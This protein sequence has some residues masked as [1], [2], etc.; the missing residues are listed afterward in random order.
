MYGVILTQWAAINNSATKT[1]TVKTGS[2]SEK[3][4]GNVVRKCFFMTQ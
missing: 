2:I 1:A 3:L 4:V